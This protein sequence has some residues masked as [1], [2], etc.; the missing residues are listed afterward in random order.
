MKRKEREW[1]ENQVE[2]QFR[3]ERRVIL[4][5]RFQM[6]KMWLEDT[7]QIKDLILLIL[8]YNFSGVGFALFECSLLTNASILKQ[9]SREYRYEDPSHGFWVAREF[10]STTFCG[11]YGAELK[12]WWNCDEG[13]KRVA[14][15]D[16]R[17]ELVQS[18][19]NKKKFVSYHWEK[20]DF[21]PDKPS[22]PAYCLHKVT[23]GNFDGKVVSNPD[24]NEFYNRH[25]INFDPL[26]TRGGFRLSF[27][28][29]FLVLWISSRFILQIYQWKDCKS[30]PEIVV[31][32]EFEKT[33]DVQMRILEHCIEIMNLQN[34]EFTSLEYFHP[35]LLPC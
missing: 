17:T 24:I 4:K 1:R 25:P 23:R 35:E 20:Y 6:T 16:R 9:Y 34:K 31:E 28:R 10:T 2:N 29:D 26:L 33:G 18:K 12:A 11:R 5:A 15:A 32:L 14:E 3:E 22:L 19:L 27:F 8:G 30:R 7:F 21:S 13:V